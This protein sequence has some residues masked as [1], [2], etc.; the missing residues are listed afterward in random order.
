MMSPLSY[1]PSERRL[2]Q[3]FSAKYPAKYKDTREEFGENVYLRDACAQGVRIASQEQLYLNDRIALEVQLPDGACALPLR[4]EVVWVK[5]SSPHYWD[6]G[7]KFYKVDL[8]NTSR[9]YKLF[10]E[11]STI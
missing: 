10:T 8:I 11:T 3:R 9:L 5:K 7:L 2:F 4:G 1:N 6:V